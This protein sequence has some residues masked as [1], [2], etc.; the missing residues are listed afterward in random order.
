LIENH[1]LA[2]TPT[3]LILVKG[4]GGVSLWLRLHAIYEGPKTGEAGVKSPENGKDLAPIHSGDPF[5]KKKKAELVRSH[6]WRGYVHNAELDDGT[7]G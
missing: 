6:L 7:D 3:K 5:E 1:V 4:R 2:G